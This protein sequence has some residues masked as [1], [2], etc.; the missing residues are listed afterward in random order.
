MDKKFNIRVYGL[1]VNESKE[2]LL[3]DEIIFGKNYTKFPGG[4]LEFGE[5]TLDCL[6]REW[7]EELNQEIKIIK[8][9][10]TTDYFQPSFLN[11]NHQVLSI[12]YLIETISKLKVEVKNTIYDFDKFSNQS[13]IFRW[14]SISLL[15]ESD[16]QLPI[17]KTVLGLLKLHFQ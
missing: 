11:A 9:F 2:V 8:H 15:K 13:Q 16:L 1:L 5:G 14:S 4:G 6:K 3:S 10:Y 7:N 12:Y 17:D